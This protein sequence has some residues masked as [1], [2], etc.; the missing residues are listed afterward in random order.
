MILNHAND[1]ATR[2]N[3]HVY[4]SI[5]GQITRFKR[6]DSILSADSHQKIILPSSFFVEFSNKRK[7]F[8]SII[9]IHTTIDA[10]S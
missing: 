5:R 2:M 9:D 4:H 10:V 8:K 6:I 7:L 3:E 1:Y